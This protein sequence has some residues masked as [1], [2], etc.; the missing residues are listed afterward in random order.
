MPIGTPRMSARAAAT[1]LNSR[2]AGSFSRMIW[3]TGLAC[4]YDIPNSPCAAWPM[5]RANC[6]T[7]LSLSPS[8]WRSRSRSARLVSCP[9]MLLIGSP[10]KLNSAN[11][12]KATTS[13]T[14]TACS[15][16]WITKA[17]IGAS[18]D[19]GLGRRTY[20]AQ[21]RNRILGVLD[22]AFPITH[23]DIAIEVD[24]AAQRGKMLR[25][26]LASDDAHFRPYRNRRHLR[27]PDPRPLRDLD[28]DV[29]PRPAALRDEH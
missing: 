14:S 28:A 10:T 4:W 13:M 27:W 23:Q 21:R 7:K 8:S 29:V 6:T 19:R 18:V 11:A 15:S 25:L 2:V 16:R 3:P 26:E 5:N 9:T 24:P 17:V 20:R 22:R 1:K 12:I